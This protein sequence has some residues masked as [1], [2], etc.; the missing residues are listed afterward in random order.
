MSYARPAM[1]ALAGALGAGTGA[2]I[3]GWSASRR[4]AE[5]HA[6]DF[7]ALERLWATIQ[8]R[9][10]VDDPKSSYTA[11][12]LHRGRKKCA[13]KLGEEST[14]VVIEAVAGCRTGVTKESADLLY[15]LFVVWA[16]VG[17]HPEDVMAELTKRE[18]ISGITEKRSR[19]KE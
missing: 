10:S 11:K 8:D 7:A 12:L 1:A 5:C 18:G 15:H 14:E 9:K 16:S 3:V 6:T 4:Q 2:G 17:V 13:Q 19:P